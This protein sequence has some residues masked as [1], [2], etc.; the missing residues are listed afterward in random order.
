MS[1]LIKFFTKNEVLLEFPELHP[2]PA[3]N[4]IPDWYKNIPIK[5]KEEGHLHSFPTR[6]SSDLD[7]S[8]RRW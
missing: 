4:F 2:Q 8:R 5:D 3:R 7:E 1:K 6:R